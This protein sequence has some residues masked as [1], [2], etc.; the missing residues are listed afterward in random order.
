MR[1]KNKGFT[2]VEMVITV[3]IFA[4]LLGILV[5][6]LNS[7][8]GFRV[9]RAANS[10]ASALDKTKIEAS[11]RL[12]GEMKLEKLE[13]GYYITYYLDRGKV[14]GESNVQEDQ[15]EKIA[16]AKTLISYTTSDGDTHQMQPGDSIVLTYDRATGG[17]LPL[18][19]TVKGTQLAYL[20]PTEILGNNS[21]TA[22]DRNAMTNP[23][24]FD[25]YNTYYS[26]KGLQE[27]GKDPVAV[28]WDTPVESWNNKTLREIGV[29]ASEPVKTVFYN[30]SENGFVYFYLNF[31]DS[32]K[33]SDFMQYFYQG[34]TKEKMDEYLAFY[35]GSNGSGINLMD[36]Q[37]Y[38]RY[39]T[40]GNVLS[41]DSS[42]QSG[43]MEVATS[44]GSPD[45]KVLQE[46]VGYQNTWYAL[47]RKMITSYDLLNTKVEEGDGDTHDETDANRSVYDNLVNEKKMVL[48]IEGQ[49]TAALKAPWEYEYT[50]DEDNGGLRAIMYHNGESST[51]KVK[52]N[53]A[54][55][56]RTVSGANTTLKITKSDEDKLRLVVCT[57]NVEIEDGVHFKGIIMAKGTLTLGVGATLESSPLE[58][59]KVFQAQISSLGDGETAKAQDFF[60]DGDKYVLGNSSSSTTGNNTNNS[61]VY[62]LADCVVYEG[63]NKE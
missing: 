33:A 24:T 36:P 23:M 10:I 52:E 7:I 17:F 56:T 21:M 12:V 14:E 11:N 43:N 46:Q 8:L 16:P 26:E 58:A 63:W 30:N 28:Q 20:A 60:W 29:D 3:A 47:N 54:E 9:Q 38:L 15:A 35:F 2:L 34:T 25:E 40:N 22:D 37:A 50:A 57:G 39:V 42:K 59:A 51:F 13:D 55:S 18:Q 31:T 4:I 53:G 44:A 6:S 41:Y 49:D 32:Q 19:E 27:D 48:F 5:P 45:A 61:D 62:D 1:Q